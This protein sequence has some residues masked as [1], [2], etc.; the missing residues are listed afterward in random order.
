M[1]S[2]KH[3]VKRSTWKSMSNWCSI[4]LL[5]PT[6][7]S[8]MMIMSYF[9]TNNAITWSMQNH[10]DCA[11]KG[12]SLSNTIHDKNNINQSFRITQL[13]HSIYI[14]WKLV[15]HHTP[16]DSDRRNELFR[17]SPEW[18][19]RWIIF[20]MELWFNTLSKSNYSVGVED[21]VIVM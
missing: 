11:M 14:F 2:A 18:W 21:Q 20:F 9:T 19:S 6:D 4:L 5:R 17:W 13:A 15:I 8:Q 16:Q 7:H 10:I 1:R 3:H 12:T